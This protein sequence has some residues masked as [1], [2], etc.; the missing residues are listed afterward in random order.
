VS[1]RAALATLLVAVGAC[2]CGGSGEEDRTTTTTTT[3]APPPP[4]RETV[5]KLPKLPAS[6]HRYVS[7]RGGFAIGL[8]RGWKAKPEGRTALIRSYDHLVAISIVPDR[9]ARAQDVPLED[10]AARTAEALPG[11]RGELRRVRA[12]AY[13]HRYDAAELRARATANGGIDE[14]LD[15]I[16]LRRDSVATVTVVIAANAKAGAHD[17]RRLARNVVATL[18][19]RPPA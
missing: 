2:G 10:F 5:D 7:R 13:R 9:S 17:S 8:P 4:A 14:R 6:W 1:A 16:V 18:R 11:I 15:V 19:T 12:H 3:T